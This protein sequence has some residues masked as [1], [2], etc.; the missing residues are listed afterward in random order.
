MLAAILLTAA[1]ASAQTPPAPA[2]GSASFTIFAGSTPIGS[3]EMTVMKIANGWRVSSTGSQRAPA[4]LVINAFEL[5]L[6]ADWHPRELKIDALL[7]SQA[8]ASTTTFGVTTAV[9]DYLQNGRKASVTHQISSR[10]I[11]LPNAFYAAYEVM[12]ARRRS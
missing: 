8:I 3:E 7:H 5:T 4:P 10:T 9:T 1:A 2:E 11:V 12:A 6:A